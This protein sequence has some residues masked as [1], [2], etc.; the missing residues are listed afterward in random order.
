H[1]FG[2]LH[3]QSGKSEEAVSKLEEALQNEEYARSA[4]YYHSVYLLIRELFKVKKKEQAL[5]YYQDVKEKLT[6]E[7]N[8]ICEAKIDILYAIYAEGGHAE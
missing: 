6:A 2:L 1:N 4:Y 3:A 8:R 5:S 7:P